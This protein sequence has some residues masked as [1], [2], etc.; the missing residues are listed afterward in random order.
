VVNRISN[1]EENLPQGSQR[2]TEADDWRL[3]CRGFSV[4]G[5]S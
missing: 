5:S 4:A 3:T 1:H 2:N